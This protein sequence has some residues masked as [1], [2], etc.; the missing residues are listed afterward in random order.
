MQPDH[1]TRPIYLCIAL[2]CLMGLVLFALDAA[3]T[4]PKPKTSKQTKAVLAT[5]EE[6]ITELKAEVK[7]LRAAK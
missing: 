4:P 1:D 7:E 5:H 3:M 6:Q 2:A